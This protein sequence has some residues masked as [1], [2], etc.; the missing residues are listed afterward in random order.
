MAMDDTDK[1]LV[2][3]LIYITVLVALAYYI[4]G[5]GYSDLKKTEGEARNRRTS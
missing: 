3:G 5:Y 2:N 1:R 4:P